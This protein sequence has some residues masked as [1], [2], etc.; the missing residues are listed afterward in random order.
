MA[1]PSLASRAASVAFVLLVVAGALVGVRLWLSYN[2]DRQAPADLPVSD[3]ASPLASSGAPQVNAAGLLRQDHE[4]DSSSRTALFKGLLEGSGQRCDEVTT[5][6]M[7]SPGKWVVTCRPGEVFSLEFD[8][9]GRLA[10]A[11]KLQSAAP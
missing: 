8:E 5:Q 6:V 11:A 4:A 1:G 7:R 10:S 9:R 2:K 3:S